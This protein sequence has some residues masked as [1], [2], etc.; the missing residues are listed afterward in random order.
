MYPYPF[1][2]VALLGWAR[3]GLNGAVIALGFILAGYAVIWLDARLPR[4]SG[5]A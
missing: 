4:G 1:I 3:T 5:T 2:N